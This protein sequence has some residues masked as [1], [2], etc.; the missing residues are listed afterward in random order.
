MLTRP[1]IS[2]ANR[3]SGWAALLFFIFLPC[4]IILHEL[5][6]FLTV[7]ALGHKATMAYAAVHFEML[8][9]ETNSRDLLLTTI[10]GPATNLLIAI[11]GALGLRSFA[12]KVD[13]GKI[14]WRWI[15]IWIFSICCCSGLRGL[16]KL[17]RS[18]ESESDEEF[19]LN[20]FEIGAVEGILI[21]ALPSLFFL[22]I[23][24]SFHFRKSSLPTL[25]LGMLTG[26]CGLMLWLKALGPALLPNP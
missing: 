19:I 18:S 5:G 25:F 4:S 11:V 3:E 23:L 24:L 6:H 16:A 9:S 13:L 8:V 12:K 17:S 1:R 10:A 7:I 20:H 22:W 14:K 21:L 26:S 15:W 2:F